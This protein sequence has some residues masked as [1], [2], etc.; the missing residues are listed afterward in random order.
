MS[1]DASTSSNVFHFSQTNNAFPSLN[2]WHNSFSLL[3]IFRYFIPIA[4]FPYD[5]TSQKRIVCKENRSSQ[6]LQSS[7]QHQQ[8][9]CLYLLLLADAVSML[10]KRRNGQL[11][12]ACSCSSSQQWMALSNNHCTLV[13]CSIQSAVTRLSLAVSLY[14]LIFRLKPLLSRC[15]RAKLV[16]FVM[17]NRCELL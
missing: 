9:T 4:L 16:S 17:K 11:L 8:Y 5:Y 7:V 13:C 12:R 6:N 3:G 15:K 10:F 14:T 2:Q 1:H